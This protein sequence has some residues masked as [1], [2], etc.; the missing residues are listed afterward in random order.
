M[1]IPFTPRWKPAIM[2]ACYCS[3]TLVTFFHNKYICFLLPARWQHRQ[4][5]ESDTNSIFIYNIPSNIKI[6]MVVNMKFM[7]FWNAILCCFIG[8]CQYLTLPWEKRQEFSLKQGFRSTN[9]YKATLF[10]GIIFVVTVT[11]LRSK[12]KELSFLSFI[13]TMQ[14]NITI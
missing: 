3:S 13:S 2:E 7:V 8:V 4:T 12:L 1:K 5:A 6:L 10:N 11:I 9:W 14:D